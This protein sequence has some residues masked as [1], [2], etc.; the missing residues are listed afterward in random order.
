MPKHSSPPA[1]NVGDSGL[2]FRLYDLATGDEDARLCCDIPDE[3]C[4]EQPKSFLRQVSAH[5][6]SKIGDVS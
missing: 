4:R 3:Q 1:V 2:A 6:L 5:A